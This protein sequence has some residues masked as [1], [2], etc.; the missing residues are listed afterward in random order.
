MATLEDVA[1]RA[2][3]S[4]STVSRVIN[5]PEKVNPRTR[6]QVEEVITALKYR[7]SRVAQR[8]RNKE[9]HAQLIGLIIPDI[10]NPFYSE[11]VRGAE[12]VAYAQD[13]AIILCNS[14]E[15]P[16]RE[17]FYLDVLKSESAD[18]VLLPP[19]YNDGSLA[20]DLEQLSLPLVCFDRRI[21]GDP[22]DTVV[23]NN[24]YGA[25][26]M[27]RHLIRLGHERIGL[28][29]GP[30]SLSTSTERALGY[31]DALEDAGC[32]VDEDLIVMDAPHRESGYTR[33][34]ELLRRDPTPTALFAANNQLALGAIEYA[35]EHGYCIP[36]DLAVVG[37]DDAPWAK[38]LDPPLTTVRQP[39]YEMGSRATELLFK[40]IEAPDRSPALVTLRPELTIRRSCGAPD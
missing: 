32:T 35:R 11:I 23:V 19:L 29:C 26:A 12:D 9:G 28:I 21:T 14:D 17:Q 20:L 33:A 4:I 40:R 5:R 22:V 13:S 39:A 3:V 30:A 8:L 2:G 27:T 1:E 34:G 10:Q 16:S 31:R 24:R 6:A 25:M 38:L 37:F 36:E 7:P 15:T 18:G